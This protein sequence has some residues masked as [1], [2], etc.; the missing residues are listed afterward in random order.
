MTIAFSR[1]VLAELI[2]SGLLAAAVVGSGTAA[3]RLS[4]G[5]VGLEL[6]ENAAATATALYAL[7]L[8]FG[9]VSGAHLNPV[10]SLV[11]AILGGLSWGDVT[12]YISAQ[13][14]GCCG[15]AVLANLMFSR[16]AVTLSTHHRASGGHLLA[17]IVATAGLVLVAFSLARTGRAER[18]PGAIAAYIGA[19]YFF[20]SSTSFANPAIALGRMLSDTFAGIAPSS[21]PLFVLAELAGGLVG[22]G[23]LRG[24]YP[25]FG[26]AAARSVTL[27]HHTETGVVDSAVESV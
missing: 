9:P 24:L 27:P 2:G 23:L 22:L 20:T 1:R 11:D 6:F 19:A 4:P 5:N 12:A 26:A 16:P 17:E 10:V 3:Q 8:V 7:L 14:A 21:V 15:G 25:D 18:A 13:V